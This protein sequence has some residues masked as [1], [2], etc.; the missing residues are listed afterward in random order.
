MNKELQVFS[1][2]A[3]QVRTVMIDGEPWFVAKD[4]A[5]SNRAVF[6]VTKCMNCR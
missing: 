5:L 1:Y 6:N 2:G 3:A 4:V